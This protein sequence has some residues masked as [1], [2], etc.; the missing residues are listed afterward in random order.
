GAELLPTGN[1]GKVGKISMVLERRTSIKEA[2]QKGTYVPLKQMFQYTHEQYYAPSQIEMCYGEGWS[3]VYFLRDGLK[4]YPK[5]EKWEAILPDY[6]KNL[7]EAAAKFRA[8]SSKAI[9]LGLE[10]DSDEIREE[11]FKTTFA[12]W[13]D[14][15]WKKL[16]EA[17]KNFGW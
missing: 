13:T 14:D 4:K 6:L 11:A 9:S 16:E 12:N 1:T 17:W 8:K 15:D 5:N 3:I 2:I 10:Q 7:Q